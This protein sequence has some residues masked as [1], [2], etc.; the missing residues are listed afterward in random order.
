MN[1]F[2]DTQSL[3]TAAMRGA[4]QRA[5]A[6]TSNLAN[7]NTP[8]YTPQDVDFH[9]AL[10]TAMSSAN[11]ASA[12]REFDAVS[13]SAQP[14]GTGAMRAD[15][16]GIDPDIESANLAQNAL[17]YQA[18]VAAAKARLDILQTAMGVR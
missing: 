17:E 3:L 16:N 13:F 7:A 12:A 8:G 10:Q 18:L 9:G 5:T 14:R 15:G 2:D 6:L 11:A 4:Q 1:L